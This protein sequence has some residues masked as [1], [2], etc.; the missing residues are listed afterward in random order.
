MPICFHCFTPGPV[1]DGTIFTTY[2]C[3]V[4]VFMV[5]TQVDEWMK[6]P[7]AEYFL[8]PA[9]LLYGLQNLSLRRDWLSS[10]LLYS[11][12]HSH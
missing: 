2:V 8:T 4:S 11:G 6:G 3:W 12:R 10:L 7:I 9:V 1:V 5:T